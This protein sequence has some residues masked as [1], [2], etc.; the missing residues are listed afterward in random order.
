M[1]R[2]RRSSDEDSHAERWIVSYADFITLLFAFFIVMYAISTLNEGKY[3]AIGN[4]LGFAFN[5]SRVVTPPSLALVGTTMP[6]QALPKAP[7]RADDAT[8]YVREQKLSG[9]AARMTEALAPLVQTGQV[10]LKKSPAGLVVEIDASVLFAPAQATLRPGSKAALTAAARVLAD[11]ENAVQ[12]EGHTDSQPIASAVYPS[13]WELASARAASVVRL[14][15]ANGVAPS[16]LL[17]VGY[18]DNRPVD[19]N[20]TAVGRA[21]NRRV[22]LLILSEPGRA[23]EVLPVLAEPVA[24]APDAAAAVRQA[25]IAAATSR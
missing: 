18:A 8:R 3:R 1:R 12:V 25:A 4:A 7:P 19:T 21:N 14:F 16:R 22:T 6:Q 11:I 17:A 23:Q 10:R 5:Q 13:N 24:L 2:R 9:I 15:S 20:E